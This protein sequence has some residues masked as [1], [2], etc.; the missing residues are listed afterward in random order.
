MD[1]PGLGYLFRSSQDS[2]TRVE[3]V[4][5][6]RPTYLPTPES[7]SLFATHERNKLPGIKAF[8]SEERIDENKRL[9]EAEKIK[10]PDE[11]P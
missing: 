9:K 2:K 8:E 5:L 7:A 4:V 1:I 3:L 6:I 10:V 11:A